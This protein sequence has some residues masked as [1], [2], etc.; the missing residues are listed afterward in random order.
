[1]GFKRVTYKLK[2]YGAYEG[3]EVRCKGATLGQV[4]RFSSILSSGLLT[5]RTDE[6]EAARQEL[7]GTLDTKLISWNLT[8]ENDEPILVRSDE[9]SALATEDWSLLLTLARSWIDAGVEI[10]RPLD[11][12][13][14]NGVPSE[15]ASTMMEPLS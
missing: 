11:L 6:G 12:A 3:L 1:M 10:S 7:I 2:F 4:V 13:S 9:G 15:V 8:D 14:Q 5:D